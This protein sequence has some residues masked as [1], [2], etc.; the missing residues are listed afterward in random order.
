MSKLRREK[1]HSLLDITNKSTTLEKTMNTLKQNV[2]T[3]QRNIDG[4]Q[5]V[6][7][8]LKRGRNEIL[9]VIDQ[10]VQEIR[11]ELNQYV[12]VIQ[13]ELQNKHAINMNILHEHESL[14]QLSLT[15]CKQD[16]A[17]CEDTLKEFDS[18]NGVEILV[19]KMKV[20]DMII[21]SVDKTKFVS[22]PIETYSMTLDETSD[23]CD[24]KRNI[25]KMVGIVLS[26]QYSIGEIQN[27][28]SLVKYFPTSTSEVNTVVLNSVNG[29]DNIWVCSGV[30][31][32]LVNF[33]ETGARLK[34]IATDFKINDITVSADGRIY[35]TS[36]DS[37]I[38]RCLKITRNG[39]V[40]VFALHDKLFLHAVAM[41][42]DNETIAVCGTDTPNYTS[43]QPNEV[44]VIE[45][46]YDGKELKRFAISNYSGKVYRLAQSINNNYVLTFP[47]EGKLL[48]VDNFNGEIK[49]SFDKN[50]FRM[51]LPLTIKPSGT[52]IEFWP[53]GLCCD[54]NGHIFVTE[55]LTKLLLM[56][57]MDCN[58]LRFIGENHA[59]PNALCFHANTGT[60][61]LGDKGKLKVWK[62]KE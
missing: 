30:S 58:M 17:K 15:V 7:Y 44:V 2:I 27:P 3:I 9:D 49:R 39:Y 42:T 40:Q 18:S 1:Y 53:S 52:S 47:K 50:D 54:T 10:R 36:P 19:N 16:I 31:N 38:L 6:E 14:L 29:K 21:D 34:T 24:M 20:L 12:E 43:Q 57:D 35:A 59:C 28:V 4:L 25:E 23:K 45:H 51:C 41:C 62:L 37:T 5:T 55:Y 11:E 33:N 46:N 32:E 56:F 60:L 13:E 26:K 22:T 48:S 61:W 8:R